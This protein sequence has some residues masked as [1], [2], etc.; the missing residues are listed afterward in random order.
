MVCS[1]RSM[2]ILHT[3]VADFRPH[4][5]LLVKDY[6]CIKPHSNIQYLEHKR[7]FGEPDLCLLNQTTILHWFTS[8][9]DDSNTKIGQL[10][11]FERLFQN[12]GFYWIDNCLLIY[13][14]V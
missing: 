14:R 3:Q 11:C 10:V 2:N 8:E 13:V 6:T 12:Y 1:I 7:E 4:Q 9:S 5:H